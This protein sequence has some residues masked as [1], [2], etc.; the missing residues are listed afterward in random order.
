M[1]KVVWVS[2]PVGDPDLANIGASGLV[3]DFLQD[4]FRSVVG[5]ET[6]IAVT[7]TRVDEDGV[8]LKA[9]LEHPH[10]QIESDTPAGGGEPESRNGINA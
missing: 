4:L 3:D 9:F 10:G 7:R 2:P 8:E 1:T 6:Q 5:I